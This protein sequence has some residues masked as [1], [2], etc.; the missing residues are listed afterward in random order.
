MPDKSMDDTGE[1]DEKNPK[2]TQ[3]SDTKTCPQRWGILLLL[4][5]VA[6]RVQLEEQT[7]L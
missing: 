7:A 3:Q 6:T 2:K 1:K 4:H 5:L